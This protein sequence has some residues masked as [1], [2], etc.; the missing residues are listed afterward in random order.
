MRTFLLCDNPL[1][2]FLLTTEDLLVLG[3][4]LHGSG[5]GEGKDLFQPA[6]LVLL[7]TKQL[8]F[9]DKFYLVP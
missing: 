7:Q 1:L 6:L 5:V 4:Y 8:R 2:K 9:L 3:T